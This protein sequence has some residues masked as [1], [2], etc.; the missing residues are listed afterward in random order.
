MAVAWEE[1]KTRNERLLVCVLDPPIPSLTAAWAINAYRRMLYPKGSKVMD[2]GGSEPYGPKRNRAA[3]QAVEEGYGGLAFLD[4]DVRPLDADIFIR[5]WQTG[6]ELVG[7]LYFRRQHPYSP[8]FA[9]VAMVDGQPVAA[10]PQGWQPGD[11]VPATFLPS[12]ATLYRTSLLERMFKRFLRPFEWGLDVAG[13]PWEEGLVPP[14]SEDY[15]FSW[16]AKHY[17]GVQGYVHTG[18]AC[19]HETRVVVGPKWAVRSPDLSDPN[20]GTIG[21]AI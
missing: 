10:T 1:V 11:L 15:V 7:G 4:S 21:E 16:R 9:D 8:A 6:L 2:A 14:N 5:L 18:L 20:L 19:L 13:V 3:K 17:L 12:G